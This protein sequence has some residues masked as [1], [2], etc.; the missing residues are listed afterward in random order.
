MKLHDNIS[1]E[2]KKEAGLDKYSGTVTI[3]IEAFAAGESDVK[4]Q[5]IQTIAE[6]D[7]EKLLDKRE[8]FEFDVENEGQ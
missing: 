2:A 4:M 7:T 3:P 5:F 8:E 1:F 6:M